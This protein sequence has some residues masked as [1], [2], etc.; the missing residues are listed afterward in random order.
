MATS[1][2]KKLE[3]LERRMN[4][5]SPPED[6]GYLVAAPSSAS[7]ASSSAVAAVGDDQQFDTTGTVMDEPNHDH[8]QIP[9]HILDT[10]ESRATNNSRSMQSTGQNKENKGSGQK[11]NALKRLM[12]AT[13]TTQGSPK[14]AKTD[15]QPSEPTVVISDTGS[16]GGAGKTRT[17]LSYFHLQGDNHTLSSGVFPNGGPSSSSA[18][19]A[20]ASTAAVVTSSSSSS[21]SADIVS[22]PNGNHR[23]SS[24][25]GNKSASSGGNATTGSSSS[26]AGGTHVST[27]AAAAAAAVEAK[28][29]YEAVRVA[30][31]LAETKISRLESDLKATED[32]QHQLEERNSKLCKSLEEVHRA[33][34]WQDARKRRDRLALDCVRLGKIVSMRMGVSVQDVWEEGYALNELK[35]RS[36]GISTHC[37]IHPIH[38]LIM[39]NQPFS[40]P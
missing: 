1:I 20:S 21:G 24:S 29:Q 5:R 6:R 9:C 13:Q 4:L 16:R 2:E 3:M 7:L 35:R 37:Q 40:Q 10:E 22:P 39:I 8:Q 32:R 31:D 27:T 25:G 17:I 12:D 30:K 33:A 14:L 28:K 11:V 38:T 26:G 18:S 19:S 36:A 23:T 34:A 15:E